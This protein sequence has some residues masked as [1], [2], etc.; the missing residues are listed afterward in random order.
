ME[1]VDILVRRDRFEDAA[2]VDLLR[3]RELNKDAVDA[4]IVVQRID[5]L[6]QFGLGRLGGKFM[7][8]RI[9]AGIAQAFSFIDT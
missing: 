9:D 2:F 8:R 3:Q 7:F 1:T 4:H 5:Q 6:E